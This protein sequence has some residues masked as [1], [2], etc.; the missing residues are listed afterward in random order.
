MK[1]A[2]APIKSIDVTGQVPDT[3]ALAKYLPMFLSEFNIYSPSMMTS[4]HLERIVFC[5]DLRLSNQK[6]A[7]VPNFLDYTLYLDVRQ[8]AKYAGYLR[9]ALHH[10][11]FH[12]IDQYDDGNLYEDTK[13]KRLNPPDFAYGNGGE[14]VQHEKNV[15]SLRGDIPGFLNLYSQSGVEEDKA[16][17]YAYMLTD[18]GMVARRAKDDPIIREKVAMIK[19]LLQIFDSSFDDKFWRNMLDRKV[20]N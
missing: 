17:I 4:A 6:R 2:N 5:Q 13:W 1:I 14:S 12:M 19:A 8:G 7:A 18:Y 11:Y 15:G 20:I 3:E 16:E 10:E 9:R